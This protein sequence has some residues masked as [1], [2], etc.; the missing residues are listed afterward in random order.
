MPVHPGIDRIIQCVRPMAFNT[1]VSAAPFSVAGTGF[2]VGYRRGVYLVSARHVVGK[3]E[4][5]RVLI[6]PTEGAISPLRLT[7]GWTFQEEEEETD[8]S[9]IFVARVDAKNLG[10]PTKRRS[11]LLNIEPRQMSNWL[12]HRHT[13][14]FFLGGYPKTD[15]YAD[16]NSLQLKYRPYLLYG[17]YVGLGS[18]DGCHKLRLKNPHHI[19]SFDGLSGSPVFSIPHA[20]GIAAQPT[21]CG[22]LIR[23]TA[24]SGIV[25]FLEAALLLV[26][27]EEVARVD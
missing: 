16:Y 19:S 12:P 15:T 13:S 7:E 21:F 20:I 11:R 22:M 10:G 17:N 8:T 14:M 18:I 1:G 2:L 9:D 26:A 23:G 3:L 4:Y 24:S 27:L 25:H 5:S 6:Y